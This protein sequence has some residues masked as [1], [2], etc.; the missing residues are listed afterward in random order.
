MN[1]KVSNLNHT[2]ELTSKVASACRGDSGGPITTILRNGEEVLVGVMSGAAGVE[3]AC[4]TPGTDGLF[5]MRVI[6]VA[7][8]LNLVPEYSFPGVAP[9]T[10]TITCIKVVKKKT[11]TKKVT[12]V[13]PTCPKGYKLK[14]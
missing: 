9:K 10:K 14:K 2:Y 3:N 1:G 6:L 12:G 7:P 13:K 4:G 5:R 11:Y 8:Y